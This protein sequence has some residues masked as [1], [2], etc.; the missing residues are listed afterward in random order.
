MYHNILVPIDG[1]DTASRGLQEAIRLAKAL[2]SQIR[3]VH[4]VDERTGIPA[5]LVGIDLRSVVEDQRRGGE[6]LLAAARERVRKEPIEVDTL[7]IEAWGGRPGALI[8]QQAK[9]WPAELVVCGTHGRRGIARLLMGSDAEE[10]V[11]QS[12]VPVL[13]IRA[14]AAK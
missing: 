4:V 7:L 3:L 12:P 13:L 8:A 6:E 2:G 14:V 9:E 10:I 5:D 11:R 1:S